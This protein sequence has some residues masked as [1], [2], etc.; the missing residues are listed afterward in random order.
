MSDA[1]RPRGWQVPQRSRPRG[2]L[3]ADL[4]KPAVA[5][6]RKKHLSNTVNY[7]LFGK[8]NLAKNSQPKQ[9]I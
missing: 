9:P 1:Q 3:S 6:T 4:T 7:I 5:G 8:K 2:G